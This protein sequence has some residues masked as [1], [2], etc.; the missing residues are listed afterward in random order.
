VLRHCLVLELCSLKISYSVNN[1]I[2]WHEHILRMN[3]DEIPKKT[4]NMKLEGRC[5]RGKP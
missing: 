5:P 3:K 4:L 1:R 2:R